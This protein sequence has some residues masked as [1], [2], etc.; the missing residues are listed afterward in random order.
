MRWSGPTDPDAR[1]RAEDFTALMTP[2][3][4]ALFTDLG[5]EATNIGM[6]VY[7]GHGYIRDHGMEQLVRDA[8]IS[9]IYEGTNGIQ[10]LDLVG[11]KLPQGAGRMLRTFFHPVS[12]FIEQH[13]GHP[14]LGEMIKGLRQGVRRAAAGDR[15]D[16]AEGDGGP[17]GSRRG[18]DRVSAP[19]RAGGAGLHV[20]ADRR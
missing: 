6:Q 7:G 17:G 3:V 12:D 9:M 4:K 13:S 19:V 10:A 16:R 18:G 1:K 14:Q 8:R 15:A 2:V 11:R 20:G 5:F